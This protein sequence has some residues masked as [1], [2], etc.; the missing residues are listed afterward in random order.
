MSPAATSANTRMSFRGDIASFSLGDVFQNLATNQKTG[1]LR[2]QSRDLECFVLFRSGKAVSSTDNKNPPISAWLVEKEIVSAAQMEEAQKRYKRAKKKCLGEILRD[3]DVIKLEDYK[4]Y[5]STL[6]QESLY[7][8]LSLQE[9]TFEFLEGLEED[10]P[11]REALALGLGFAAQNLLM[12]GA[13]R[14]DDWQN[15][16]RHMPSESEIYFV[17]PSIRQRLLSETEDEVIKQAIELLDGT[18]TLKKIIAKLPYTRFDTCRAIA[19]LITDKTLRPLD[20]AALPEVAANKEDPR[21]VLATLKAI[22]ER[23]PNNREILER[24]A[25][26]CMQ[27]GTKDEAA[28]FWKRLALSF[29]EEGL[30][31]S[32]IAGLEQSIELNPKDLAAWEKLEDAVNRT[33]DTGRMEAISLR[34]AQHFQ[35]QGLPEVVRD[36][37][38]VALQR[39]PNNLDLHL[40]LATARFKLGE[41]KA[42]VESLMAL[43]KER[44]KAGDMISAER[45]L[46]A[47]LKLDTTHA[48][49][50]ALIDDIQSGATARRSEARRKAWREALVAV[51]A[52]ALVVFLGYDFYVRHEL[53][54][55]TRSVYAESR[56]DPAKERTL[57]ERLRDL[58]SRRPFSYTTLHELQTLRTTLETSTGTGAR[59]KP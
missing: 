1:T 47:V 11:N 26:L 15:I 5:V 31:P 10:Q 59:Q 8:A 44:E 34:F 49:A 54:S 57:I 24:I 55:I 9:G 42:S 29:L 41:H 2:V 38:Q 53:F 3:L 36:H 25:R 17:P 39:F 20:G 22:L 21:E 18:R 37:L 33:G 58:E 35:K 19:Q 14:S 40:A 7:E 43:G 27:Y 51:G 16:R 48:Q 50:R 28:T 6:V 46:A 30:L 23:E 13:R 45:V 32:A 56:L 52:A 4:H 12:E